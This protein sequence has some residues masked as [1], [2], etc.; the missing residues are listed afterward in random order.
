MTP[1]YDKVALLAVRDNRILLCRKKHTTALL[2]L[3]GG[4]LESGESP[5]QCLDRELREELGDVRTEDIGYVG[6][7]TH[8]AAGSGPAK[9]VRIELYRANLI[10]DP[11][12]HSEIK[13]LVWFGEDDNRAD[14]ASSLVDKILPDVIAR[15]I[16]AW[17]L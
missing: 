3:P 4:C 13:E 17:H 16:L 15:G 6:T 8:R 10:G 9:T 5:S 11:E 2:I 1:D 7:Y 12:P 14:L